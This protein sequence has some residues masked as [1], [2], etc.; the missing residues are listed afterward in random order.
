MNKINRKIDDTRV[1]FEGVVYKQIPNVDGRCQQ[2]SFSP[3]RCV[4]RF[5]DFVLAEFHEN[6]C[7]NHKQWIV[8][9]DYIVMGGE[10]LQVKRSIIVDSRSEMEKKIADSILG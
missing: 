8:D 7:S 4:E 1:M 6:V 3:S 10:P 9:V 2:C 5:L